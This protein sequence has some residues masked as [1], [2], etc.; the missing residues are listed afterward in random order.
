MLCKKKTNELLADLKED[1]KM[2]FCFVTILKRKVELIYEKVPSMV[3]RSTSRVE[4]VKCTNPH[5]ITPFRASLTTYD[6]KNLISSLQYLLTNQIF[7]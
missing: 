7:S 3:G 6:S 5:C 2:V 1:F 4:S